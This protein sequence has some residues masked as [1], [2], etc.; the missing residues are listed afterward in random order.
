[1]GLLIIPHDLR[2]KARLKAGVSGPVISP[3]DPSCRTLLAVALPQL[4]DLSRVH[5]PPLGG[6]RCTQRLIDDR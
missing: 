4:P 1:M 5:R 2:V 3:G 6:V